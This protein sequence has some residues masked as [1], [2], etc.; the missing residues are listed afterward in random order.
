[1]VKIRTG[2]IALISLIC[3]SVPAQVSHTV[4][5]IVT[6]SR[7]GVSIATANVRVSETSRGTITNI[8][9]S[10]VLSLPTGEYTLIYS[11]VGYRTDSLTV[12]L[13]SDVS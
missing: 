7:T 12:I 13:S 1:M 4:S 6:D 11:Y 8:N 2:L 5:G 9:G 10:Y 3:S